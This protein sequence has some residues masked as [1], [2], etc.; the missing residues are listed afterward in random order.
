MPTMT[1]LLALFAIAAVSLSCGNKGD[2]RYTRKEAQKSL[3][4]LEKPGVVVGEFRLSRVVD[5][6][7]V[8]VD[9][10]DASLRL[11]GIDAEETFKNEGDRR[12]VEADW[13]G[14]LK[15]KR[16]HS[17]RPVKLA[18]PVGEQAKTWGKA[19]FAGIEKVRI[20]RDHP[21]EIRD[22]Y[23]RYLA[24]V[25]A[26][27]G[28]KMLVYNVELVRAGMSPYFPK[29]G[30][31]RRYHADF[32][33]AQDEAKAA[34]RG[35]WAP[36]TMHAPDYPEREE[37]W[38]ARGKFVDDFRKEGEGKA[39]YIDITHWDALKE[40]ESHLGKEV[41]VLGTV[42]DVSTGT[43]GPAR[44]ELARSRS[45]GFPLIFFDRDVLGTTGLY[46]WKGE[47][48]VVTGVPTEYTNKKTG[49]KS[50]QIQVDRATQIKLS[51]IPGLTPPSVPTVTSSP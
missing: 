41:K 11:L 12:A 5:G 28:G 6:D 43:K 9:G 10:L 48:V 7:T 42:S 19:F 45:A 39:N 37:W 50:L 23:N 25:V 35:I 51:T 18:T 30:Y 24:Y 13:A 26:N 34:K 44:V 31:S 32:I 2:R 46:E 36:D 17:K 21:A 14:Y 8:W 47:Y 16:G 3:A 38:T 22:V 20:E 27:K 1:R 33:Q 4:K 29:Y 15:T 40:I 49:K